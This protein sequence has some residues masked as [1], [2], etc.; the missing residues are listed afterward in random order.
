MGNRAGQWADRVAELGGGAALAGGGG[1]AAWL[2][3]P[4]AGVAPVVLASAVAAAG[5]LLGWAIV[6]AAPGAKIP[7]SMPYFHL[8]PVADLV[9]DELAMSL[10][11][12][13]EAEGQ[14]EPSRVVQLFDPPAADTPGAMQ[15]RIAAYLGDSVFL[16]ALP[17][18]GPPAPWNGSPA[19]RDASDALHAALDE[20]RLSLRAG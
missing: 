19:I 5:G 18:G 9:A 17:S 3:A 13:D 16:A 10:L 20:I 1:A 12:L 8:D 15:E 6:R 2:I 11:L 14:A 4:L 7:R